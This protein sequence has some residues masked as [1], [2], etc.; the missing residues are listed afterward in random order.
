M[1][2]LPVGEIVLGDCLTVMRSWP[3]ASIDIRE[4]QIKL[5][6]RRLAATAPLLA[7]GAET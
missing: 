7:K 2:D 1:P 4:S 3:D 6:R 5:A